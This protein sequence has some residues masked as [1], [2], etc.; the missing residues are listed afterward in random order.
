M[1]VLFPKGEH[2]LT[3]TSPHTKGAGIMLTQIT[4]KRYRPIH[5]RM[6]CSRTALSQEQVNHLSGC[7]TVK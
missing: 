2:I 7:C 4:L 5:C 6:C 1:I 3:I